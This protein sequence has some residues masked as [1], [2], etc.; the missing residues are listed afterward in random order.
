MKRIVICISIIAVI[1]AVGIFTLYSVNTK[2]DRLYGHIEAVLSAY[3]SG[4]DVSAEI[5]SL[6]DYFEN[7]YVPCLACIINDD[8]LSDIS[9]QI[10]RLAPMYESDCDEFTSECESIRNGARKIY[11]RELPVWFRIL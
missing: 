10:S 7:D 1:I 4:G 3:E 6:T 2:N 9:V 5:Q 11:Y 8:L